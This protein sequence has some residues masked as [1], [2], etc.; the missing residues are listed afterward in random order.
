MASTSQSVQCCIRFPTLP[1]YGSPRSAAD[2]SA[3]F[4]VLRCAAAGCPGSTTGA[5]TCHR[6]RLPRAGR[7]AYPSPRRGGA[8]WRR[9]SAARSPSEALPPLN[10][11]EPPMDLGSAKYALDS[12]HALIEGSGFSAG[13]TPATVADEAGCRTGHPRPSRCQ[14]D[15]HRPRSGPPAG[16]NRRHMQQAVHCERSGAQ[17]EQSRREVNG[18][19][20]DR[21]RTWR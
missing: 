21:C 13:D 3:H 9:G 6:P 15:R 14:R 5:D 7:A 1:L 10:T 12:G 19:V 17:R 16:R 20:R 11:P 8:Q 4:I 18:V 2:V